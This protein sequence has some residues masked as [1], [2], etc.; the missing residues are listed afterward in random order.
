V[1]PPPI[2]KV[3]TFLDILQ[4]PAPS[5]GHATRCS[6]CSS[7]LAL[8]QPDPQDP[9]R[10]LGVCGRC[11]HWFLVDLLHDTSEGIMVRLPDAEVVRALSHED[12]SG[13]ISVTGDADVPRG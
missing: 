5:P 11:K 1:E 4:F 7:S 12:E 6:N 2:K 13:G 3:A 9:S 8:H 10:L